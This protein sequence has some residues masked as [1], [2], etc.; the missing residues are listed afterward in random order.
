MTPVD[1]PR[2][3]EVAPDRAAEPSL[4]E[5]ARR[6]RLGEVDHR[7]RCPYHPAAVID[8][9]CSR[10]GR[11]LCAACFSL[12]LGQPRCRVCRAESLRRRILIAAVLLVML[13]APALCAVWSYD[14]RRRSEP[15]GRGAATRLLE[16]SSADG[17]VRM[18]QDLIRV[19]RRDAA[20]QQLLRALAET[21]DHL[22]SLLALAE[23]GAA[24]RDWESVRRWAGRA[25]QIAPGAEAARLLDARACLVLGRVDEADARL[26]DGLR[27]NPAAAAIARELARLLVLRER[28][29]EAAAVLKAALAA[30]PPGVDRPG[31]QS[32]LDALGP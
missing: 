21:P 7:A 16:P 19:G 5:L 4:K 2:P 14:Q 31:L 28:R 24:E 15:A 1:P 12:V 6:R 26:R 30:G 11:S 9:T 17:R 18:A 3:D 22:L 20:R 25:L 23:I 27:L 29:V 10:C 32:D 13:G 8:T